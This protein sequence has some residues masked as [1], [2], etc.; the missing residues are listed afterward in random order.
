V[1]DGPRFKQIL[2]RASKSKPV[3][4]WK[5]GSTEAGAKAAAS[6]TGALSGARDIWKGV[7]T[8]AGAIQ[9][10]SLEEALDCIY[11]FNTQP[12]PKGRR[13]AVAT[14]PGGPAVGALDVCIEMGLEAACLGHATKARV[15]K[16]IPP[17]GGSHENPVDLTIAAI[18]TP[19]MFGPVI[20]QL[21]RDNNV[22]MIIVIG[23]GGEAFNQAIINASKNLHKPIAVAAIHPL[24]DISEDY[25]TLLNEKIPVYPDPWR[26][27]NVMAKLTAY[28]EFRRRR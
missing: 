5:C 21:N 14:G 17:F 10:G 22:D 7:L 23:L 28:A 2:N 26:C 11:M 20:D 1:T 9:I 16:I 27:A 24:A 4:V 13:V 25:Q 3:I 15:K 12:L 6:H 19:K 18:E 8:G